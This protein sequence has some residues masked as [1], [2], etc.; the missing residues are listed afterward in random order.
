M[1]HGTIRCRS[2]GR[3]T[4]VL[5][6]KPRHI[7]QVL[8]HSAQNLKLTCRDW[9]NGTV[10]VDTHIFEKILDNIDAA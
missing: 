1:L 6:A 8:S 9:Y 4:C 7:L 2:R 3:A 5:D 10:G